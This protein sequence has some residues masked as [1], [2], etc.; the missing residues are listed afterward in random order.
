MTTLKTKHICVDNIVRETGKI[1]TKMHMKITKPA[2]HSIS[3]GTG[4][5]RTCGCVRFRPRGKP[6]LL[7]MLAKVLPA[8]TPG[9]I[10]VGR[11]RDKTALLIPSKAEPE[12]DGIVTSSGVAVELVA[13]I[14]GSDKAVVGAALLD[15]FRC[16][17]RTLQN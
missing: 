1:G 17:G 3:E 14:A 2:I 6:Q 11:L 5:A 12:G 8:L 4:D 7:A 9:A 16:G 10:D 13:G 15:P